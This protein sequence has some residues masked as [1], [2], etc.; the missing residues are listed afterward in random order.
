MGKW[1]M[2]VSAAS[3]AAAVLGHVAGDGKTGKTAAF[4][5]GIV[6]L[7]AVLE[8]TVTLLGG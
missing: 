2:A 1:L 4:A 7:A 6:Y 8:A 3:V 5:V